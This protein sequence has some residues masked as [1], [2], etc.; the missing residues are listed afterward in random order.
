MSFRE[1]LRAYIAQL[2]RRLRWSTLLR[3]FAIL[4]GTALVATLVLVIIANAL[5]FSQGS[6][7]NSR[8]GLILILAIAAARGWLCHCAASHA[9]VP[10]ERLKPRSRN[11]NSDSPR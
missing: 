8:F 11:S 7:T 2:E 6:V 10:S 4:T 9:S 5:A 3:G 1:Q